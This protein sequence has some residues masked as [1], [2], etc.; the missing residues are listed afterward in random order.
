ME[1]TPTLRLRNLTVSFAGQD[2]P[3]TAVDDLNLDVGAGEVLA[4]VGESGSGKTTT[5][6]SALGLQRGARVTGQALLNGHNLLA[7]SEAELSKLRGRDVSVIFQDALASLNPV[8]AIGAQVAEAV[9]VHHH[10]LSRAQVRA[11]SLELL[12]LVGIPAP[13]E[14]ATQYP[15]Q[16]SGGMRQRV[17]IAI[18]IANEPR[19]IVADEPTTALDVTIQAQVIDVLRR[20]HENTDSSIVFITHDLG[21]VAGIADRVAVLY[22]GKLAEIGAT[23]DVF[24]NASHPYTAGLLA[25][26]PRVDTGGRG[27]RLHQIDG[28][29]PRDITSVSGC[30]FHPRCPMAQLPGPCSTVRPPMINAV[31]EKNAVG[32]PHMSACH[33]ADEV[34]QHR[35]VSA[36]ERP[37]NVAETQPRHDEVLIEAV[38]VSKHFPLHK[39]SLR[40]SKKVTIRAVDNVSLQVARGE[41]LGLVGESGSGKTTVAH[42]LVNLANPT[43]GDVNVAGKNL[44]TFSRKELRGLATRVQFVFQDPFSSLNPQMTVEQIL[45]EPLKLNGR[46]NRTAGPEKVATTLNLVGLDQQAAARHASAFSGGQR[47]RIGIARALMLEP[48]VLVL[49]EPVSALDVSVR[50][51]IMNLLADLQENLGVGYLFVAHDLAVVRHISDRVAVMYHGKIVEEGGVERLYTAPAH[52]YT[53]AL[54]SSVPIPDPDI[55][56]KRER[57]I[58]SGD[59]PSPAD[60]PSGCRFRTRCWKAQ[61]MC[62]EV[63]P[64][65]VAVVGGG[66]VSC[67]FPESP[68]AEGEVSSRTARMEQLH[69]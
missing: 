29:P 26:L 5:F 23:E 19:L 51:G 7:A 16:L 62:A 20:I 8:M 31:G 27:T 2:T 34:P 36:P 57:I 37:A 67:H 54:L 9:T 1:P 60:P 50:A 42:M 49:D 25:C 38:G 4:V 33:F 61:D 28:N 56:R 58:L 55:E 22:G 40:R 47:Q 39:G 21:V 43:S 30:V 69:G 15:H 6:L 35:E 53:I 24:Y 18:A 41:T 63:E 14:R 65:P 66:S 11:K 13:E 46:W 64:A 48:Q 10:D 12:R 44:S 3:V 68:V 52:P 17:M 32:T 45:A 59:Q